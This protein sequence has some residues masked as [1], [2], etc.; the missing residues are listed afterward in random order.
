[1]TRRTVLAALALVAALVATRSAAETPWKMDKNHS[2]VTFSVAHLVISEV[3]G[4]FRDFEVSFVTN[5]DDFS[6]AKLSAT[7]KVASINTENDRRDNHLRSGDFLDA[8]HFPD[9]IFASTSVSTTGDNSFDI[10]GDLTIR[11][12]TKPIVLHAE[13]KGTIDMKGR[14]IIAFSAATEINRFDYGVKWDAKLETGGLVAGEKVRIA[15]SYEGI[16]Q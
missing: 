14:T 9:L 1:M 16:K 13:Y 7:I 2:S 15:I 10:A 6:D 12:T 8:E 11:G 4:K 3:T 5:K